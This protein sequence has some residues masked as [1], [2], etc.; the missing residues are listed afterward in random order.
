MGK[1]KVKI[2]K[3]LMDIAPGYLERRKADLGL[4]KDA[5]TRNDFEFIENRSHKTKGTAAGYGFSELTEIAYAL[6]MAAKTNNH[7][8]IES[9]LNQM[10][11][12]L[13][14]IEIV[15]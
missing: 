8:K 2:P 10:K 1:I 3:D 14:D 11:T 5:L 9:V 6:E 4:L 12:Y 13:Q 15:T 7:E